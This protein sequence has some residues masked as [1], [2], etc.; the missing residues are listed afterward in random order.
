MLCSEYT[1]MALK[2]SEQCD[3]SA[4]L[5]SSGAYRVSAQYPE[6]H[7]HSDMTFLDTPTVVS[8]Q[9]L[10]ADWLMDSL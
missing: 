6:V 7:H 4:D 5:A 2:G 8:T 3:G 10:L 9:K 1:S